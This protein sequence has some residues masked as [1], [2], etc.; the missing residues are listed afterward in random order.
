MVYKDIHKV[1]WVS[2]SQYLF[3]EKIVINSV[4]QL[5]SSQLINHHSKKIK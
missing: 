4:S 5:N 2:T 3:K 1:L